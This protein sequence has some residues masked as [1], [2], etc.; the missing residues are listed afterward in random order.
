LSGCQRAQNE[1]LV[2]PPIDAKA[3][4]SPTALR[5]PFKRVAR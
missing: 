3:P 4:P 1:F 2:A 5:T